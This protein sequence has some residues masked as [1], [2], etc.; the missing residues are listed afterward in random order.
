[1][2]NPVEAKG[3]LLKDHESCKVKANINVLRVADSFATRFFVGNISQDTGVEP[4]F[5]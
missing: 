3:S 5:A 2:V 4:I 1:M